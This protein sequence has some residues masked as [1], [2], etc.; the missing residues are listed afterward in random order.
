MRA[1][2]SLVTGGRARF[3]SVN[4]FTGEVDLRGTFRTTDQVVDIALPLA[5]R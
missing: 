3:Y 1:F 4:L 5:Q 2:A